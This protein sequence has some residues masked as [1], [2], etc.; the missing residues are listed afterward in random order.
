MSFFGFDAVLP[1]RRG[2]NGAGAEED[3]AVYTWGAE[4]FDDLGG[5]LVEGGDEANDETF[6]DMPIT[7]DF[8][9]SHHAPGQVLGSTANKATPKKSKKGNNTDLFAST[10]ADFFGFSKKSTKPKVSN[11]ISKPSSV[12]ISS[13]SAQPKASL[14]QQGLWSTTAPSAAFQAAS[15]AAS[16]ANTNH[17]L[18]TGT[19]S[20]A[21][22]M[23][24]GMRTLEEIEAEL[25][26]QSRAKQQPMTL[27]EI[28]R[29]MM[30][31]LRI[32]AAAAP[33][34]GAPHGVLS[35]AASSP[36]S[37]PPASAYQG[38]YPVLSYPGAAQGGLPVNVS[39]AGAANMYPQ[40]VEGNQILAHQLQHVQ[41]MPVDARSGNMTPGGHPATVNPDIARLLGINAQ[42]DAGLSE[43]DRVNA[44]LERK[45]KETEIAEMKRR[46][47]A[48]KIGNMSR[49]NDIMTQ[50]ESFPVGQSTRR[51]LKSFLSFVAGDKEFITR[52][53][54]SQLVT[55]DPYASDFYA[56][57]YSALAQQRR[58]QGEPTPQNP[59]VLQVAGGRGLGVGVSRSL[60]SKRLR[61]NA[62]Q[63]MTMQVKRIVENAHQR[64][65][66]VPT[67]SLQG[68]LGKNKLRPTATAPRPALQ[69]ASSS[70]TAVNQSA[71]PSDQPS[72]ITSVLGG[73]SGT[74]QRQPL[75][76]KQ[77]L[78]RLEELFEAVLEVEQIRRAQPPLPPQNEEQMQRMGM[79]PVEVEE[80]IK[81][82]QQWSDSVQA[83]VD[84]LWRKLMVQEPLEISNPHPFIALLGPIK[85][86]RIFSRVIRHFDHSRILTMV[87]LLLA[88]FPQLDVVRNAPPPTLST[89]SSMPPAELALRQQKER[90]LESFSNNVI[91]VMMGVINQ[92]DLKMVAGMINL[93]LERWDMKTVL[94]TRPG[95]ALMMSLLAR[96]TI[97][98]QGASNPADPSAPSQSDIQQWEQ[99]FLTLLHT[100]LPIL[101][102]LFPSTRAQSSA[103]G[104]GASSES[105]M[106]TRD[107]AEGIKMDL[108]DGEVWGLCTMLAAQATGDD[109]TFLVLSLRD[110]IRYTFNSAKHQW[111][112]PQ[113]GEIRLKNVDS[114]L[115]VLG[116]NVSMLN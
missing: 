29:E 115:G 73:A 36:A 27:E 44:E 84:A 97:L 64:Q 54:L 11:A 109:T 68:A 94:S 35:A 39:P 114:F 88:C 112:S 46:K 41:P 87:I 70:R 22:P 9:F 71:D 96:G 76:K 61:D 47:K 45:I 15:A 38:H 42:Q 66:A 34:V 62:M 79:T 111:V 8:R 50:G 21:V 24:V 32:D 1:E 89:S 93:C 40:Q 108:L 78:V 105:Q 75:T 37:Q 102:S 3:I 59:S 82:G 6:G 58:A 16:A 12:V 81:R 99:A 17:L 60:G 52:I 77:V 67:A 90:E 74:A 116:M 19:Q 85:G 65:K 20:Q 69:V 53:Q 100:L 55:D 63:R 18:A 106:E 95:L 92:H 48:M 4:G 107:E 51:M 91:S 2:G 104:P 7:D 86:H 98:K 5:Q 14:Q 28:E 13:S 113:R 57:V 110:K 49:Y 26:A 33:P 31:N 56:Q 10:E 83:A 43:D 23:P 72:A 25:L 101:S 30:K 80:Q 103:F